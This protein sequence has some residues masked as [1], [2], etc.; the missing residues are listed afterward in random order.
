MKMMNR[1][2]WV[3]LSRNGGDDAKKKEY[4]DD[5]GATRMVKGRFFE[6]ATPLCSLDYWKL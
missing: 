1:I 4:F 6:P 5:D 3:S 2:L